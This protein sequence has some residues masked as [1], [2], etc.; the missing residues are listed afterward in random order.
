[1]AGIRERV[2]FFGKQA[3]YFAGGCPEGSLSIKAASAQSYPKH[4]LRRELN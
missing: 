2:Q 3:L 4:I 1:M